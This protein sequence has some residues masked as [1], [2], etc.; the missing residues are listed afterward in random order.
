MLKAS[1]T[2][3]LETKLKRSY[4][5]LTQE[6]HPT[7][8]SQPPPPKKKSKRKQDPKSTKLPNHPLPF[9]YKS[10]P[11]LETPRPSAP[12]PL[13]S[14]EESLDVFAKVLGVDLALEAILVLLD[15]A[16]FVLGSVQ[17][18]RKVGMAL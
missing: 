8:Q 6:L 17:L 9:S 11:K 12:Q 2:Q 4:M 3:I 5:N 15:K 10:E 7:T 18:L 14:L 1:L 13:Y 16:L